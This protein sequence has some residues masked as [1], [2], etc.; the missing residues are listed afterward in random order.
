MS[1]WPQMG[2]RAPAALFDWL[3]ERKRKEA[4]SASALIRRLILNYMAQVDRQAYDAFVNPKEK[5]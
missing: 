5:R 4:V 3:K 2:I 1:N